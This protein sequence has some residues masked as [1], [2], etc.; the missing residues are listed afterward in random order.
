MN[1]LNINKLQDKKQMLKI[2]ELKQEIIDILQLDVKPRNIKIAYDRIPHCEKH[3]KDF[4]NEQSY[5]KS[6]E[7]LPDIINNP[8]YVGYNSNNNGIEYIKRIE[9]LTLVVVR[10][11]EKGDLFLRSVYPISEIKLKN[12]IIAGEYK[13][14]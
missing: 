12:K 13:K 5:N 14:I 10:F 6:M 1:E 4:V 7:L 3:K 11:K 9:E 2:G 8:D